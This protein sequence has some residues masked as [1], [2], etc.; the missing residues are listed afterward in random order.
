M[1]NEGRLL[2][3]G[4]AQARLG[5]NERTLRKYAAAGKLTRVREKNGRV[6]FVT[7]DVERLAREIGGRAERRAVDAVGIDAIPPSVSWSMPGE[8]AGEDLTADAHA[9]EQL[10]LQEIQWLRAQLERLHDTHREFCLL[11]LQSGRGLDR[12]PS[13]GHLGGKPAARDSR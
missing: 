9:R 7:E 5:V 6:R 3:A 13:N 2:T 1:Q 10:L 8:R 4:Q 12:L 11:L